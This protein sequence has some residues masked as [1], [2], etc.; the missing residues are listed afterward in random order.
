[1]SLTTPAASMVQPA[2]E[3][4]LLIANPGDE[5]VYYYMEG[6]AAPQ[7][8]FPTYGREPRAV[9]E[10]ERNLRERTPGTYETVMKLT[11]AGEFDLAMMLDKPRIA[12]CFDFAVVPDPERLAASQ[13]RVRI[14]GIA[15]PETVAA[16][17]EVVLRLRVINAANSQPRTDLDDVIALI[18]APGVWQDRRIARHVGAGVYEIQFRPPASGAYAVHVAV[19]SEGFAY[20]P[21]AALTVTDAKK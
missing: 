10:I 19:P 8:N 4:G 7:G 15:I 6:A 12:H 13:P 1:M 18:M 16:G 21:F 11:S 14:E 3:D 5:A 20:A 2:G 17:E 9:M